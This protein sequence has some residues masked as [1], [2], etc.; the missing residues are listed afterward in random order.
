MLSDPQPHPKAESAI[1]YVHDLKQ[2]HQQVQAQLELAQTRMENQENRH[3]TK[4]PQLKEGDKV[5]LHTKNL[6]TKRPSKKLDHIR[7]GPFVIKRVK[8][9]VNYELE[10]PEDAKVHP[11]FHISLLEKASDREPTT[12]TFQ[13][14]SQ[15]DNLFKVEAILD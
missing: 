11:V 7:V 4:G 10:L 14:K 3:R 2:V 9:P 8:G 12:T 15:K 1:K 13:Y 6:R 5:W